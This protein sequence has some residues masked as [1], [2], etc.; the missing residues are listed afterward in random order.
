MRVAMLASVL[1][2][3]VPRQ[4][5]TPSQP[6]RDPFCFRP[7]EE[8]C[9]RDKCL[10]YAAQ[11]ETI[12]AGGYSAYVA[13]TKAAGRLGCSHA[14][15]VGKCG[16]L[17]TTHH[18]D[19]FTG[20]TRYFS[21]AGKLIAVRVDTDVFLKDECPFWTHYGAAM[22]CRV[23]DRVDARRRDRRARYLESLARDDGR[24][25]EKAHGKY[26]LT[27][28]ML[29]CPAC[30]GHF[31]ARKYPW[32]GQPGDVYMCSTRRR[33]PGVCK[34]TLALPIAETDY[35]VLEMI[36]SQVLGD[37]YIDELL[38]LVDTSPDPTRQLEAD[39]E[40]LR[41]E[42]AN[43]VRSIAIGVPADTVAPEIRRL[44]A[45]VARIDVKL[46]TPRAP[47]PDLDKLRAA[48]EHRVAT[49]KADL[50]SEPKVARLV[51]RRIVGPLLLWD[52][53]EIP[54]WMQW[55]APIKP[56]GLL[57]GLSS[58]WMASPTGAAPFLCA[59]PRIVISAA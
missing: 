1:L 56:E 59:D 9:A 10:T 23:A 39:R 25:P 53:S 52:S 4:A 13:T 40:R 12:R 3:L 16:P 31:E 50:R 44:E 19:A 41:A 7:L 58:V 5:Y 24:M 21:E 17:R 42:V 57:D 46:R 22:A 38:S 20:E 14:G 34:N 49:W 37:R 45:E 2:A 6:T 27:G 36:Q 30:N 18:S 28:G 8:F 29:V 51:L 35:V 15:T 47:R 43:L 48:L 26:L 55:E 11:L 33:K 54:E 32:K